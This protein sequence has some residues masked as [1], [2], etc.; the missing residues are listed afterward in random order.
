MYFPD[1]TICKDMDQSEIDAI[2]ED[3]NFVHPEEKNI[4]LLKRAKKV[5]NSNLL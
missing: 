1:N 3:P 5:I 4:F 2:F